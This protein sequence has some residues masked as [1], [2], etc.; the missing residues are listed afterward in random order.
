MRALEARKILTIREVAEEL[1]CSKAHVS[2]ILNGKVPGL[3]KLD[4]VALGRRKLVR[5]DWL[6]EWI[7]SNRTRC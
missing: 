1:K 5:S 7:E 4:H 3:A 6:V 2:K